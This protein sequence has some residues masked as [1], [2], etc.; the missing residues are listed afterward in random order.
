M[1]GDELAFRLDPADRGVPEVLALSADG[2]QAQAKWGVRV[3]NEILRP[4]PNL[5]ATHWREGVVAIHG[6]DIRPGG[7]LRAELHDIAPTAL[8]MLGLRI[9]DVMEGRVIQEAFEDPLPVRYGAR[10]VIAADPQ[11]EALLAAGFGA[12]DC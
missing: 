5:P 6:P 8:A 9:P 4:D 1:P 2:Y 7:H 11:F 12:T 3:R 10:P